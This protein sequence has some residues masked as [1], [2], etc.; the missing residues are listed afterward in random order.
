MSPQLLQERLHRQVMRRD[1]PH[2]P[3]ASRYRGGAI[4]CRHAA[5]AACR[6]TA[7]TRT[8]GPCRVGR[9]WRAA[10]TPPHRR[11]QHD[12][13]DHARHAALAACLCLVLVDRRQ[14]IDHAQRRDAK[15]STDPTRSRAPRLAGSFDTIATTFP[16]T[17]SL[18]TGPPRMLKVTILELFK[19]FHGHAAASKFSF[20]DFS[21]LLTLEPLDSP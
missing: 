14:S 19:R 18:K 1:I 21:Q 20:L 6:M 15:H 3:S 17:N 2:P 9:G 13:R 8:C 11:P 12:I 10:R 4:C 16:A 5:N 7:S